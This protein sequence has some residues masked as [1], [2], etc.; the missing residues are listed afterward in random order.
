MRG[1]WGAAA[2]ALGGSP[3]RDAV[4]ALGAG[5]R[6]RFPPARPGRC[7]AVLAPR[8]GPA[9]CRDPSGNKEPGDGAGA[10]SRRVPTRR[11]AT[12][13]RRRRGPALFA[14]G[15]L[16]AR[17]AARSGAGTALPATPGRGRPGSRRLPKLLLLVLLF[18]Y[19]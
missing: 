13:A 15:G 12:F 4:P 17:P 2:A 16:R 9:R 10:A 8:A 14:L 7:P 6:R 1:V 18:F 19:F 3:L 11:L 5:S